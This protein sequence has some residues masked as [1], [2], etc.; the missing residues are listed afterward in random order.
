[1]LSLAIVFICFCFVAVCF[2]FSVC[3][4][5]LDIEYRL[6]WSN[7]LISEDVGG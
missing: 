7:F 4:G 3:F 2:P 6:Q 5:N 1:M